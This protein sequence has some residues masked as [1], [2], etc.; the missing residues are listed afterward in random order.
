MYRCPY[1]QGVCGIDEQYV[2]YT[3]SDIKCD[4]REKHEKKLSEEIAKQYKPTGF[5][6]NKMLTD[7]EQ[8]EALIRKSYLG[9]KA[10]MTILDDGRKLITLHDNTDSVNIVFDKDGN[11]L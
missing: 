1:Y 10:E 11:I 6:I 7:L 9:D 8:F 4:I 5:N 3:S 2:C